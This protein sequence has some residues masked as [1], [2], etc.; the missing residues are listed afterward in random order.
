MST[1]EIEARLALLEIEVARL[2]QQLPS[3]AEQPWWQAILGTFADD[4][5]YEEAMQLGQQYR[6]SL[7]PP[8]EPAPET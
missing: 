4:P 1:P 8:A 7:R 5:A 6:E 3:A 2:K